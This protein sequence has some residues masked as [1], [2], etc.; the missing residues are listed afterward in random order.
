MLSSGAGC[1]VVDVSGTKQKR[2]DTIML[3]SSGAR[4]I[5]VDVGGTKFLTAAETLTSNS[6]YFT[7]LLRGDWSKSAFHGHHGEEDDIFLDQD[8]VAFGRLLEYM[9]RGMIKVDDVDI[10]ILILAK[11]LGLDILILAAKVCWYCNIG[12]G[13]VSAKFDEDIAATFDEV[14]GGGDGLDSKE[15]V[16]ID[17]HQLEAAVGS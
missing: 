1:I 9:R 15:Y 2:E 4:R 16:F 8:P 5:V 3:L 12:K 7:S 17:S 10:D 13:P 14:H 11:F 6:T